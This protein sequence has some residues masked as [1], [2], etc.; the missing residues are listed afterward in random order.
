MVKR[1]RNQ[2]NL[3]L[4]NPAD[5]SEIVIPD[6]YKQYATNKGEHENFLIADS[7]QSDNTI[8]AMV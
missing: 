6:E 2:S 4:L 1:R 3:A 8:E 5:V 7:G